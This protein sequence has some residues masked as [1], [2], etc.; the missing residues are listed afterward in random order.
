MPRWREQ[1]DEL[2]DGIEMIV[3]STADLKQLHDGVTGIEF[4]KNNAEN[5]AV[6]ISDLNLSS[7]PNEPQGYDVIAAALSAGIPA[8]RICMF[9]TTPEA[10]K[11][12][13]SKITKEPILIFDKYANNGL[14][15]NWLIEKLVR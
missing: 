2:Y 8:E 15:S 12:L 6:V 5:I 7:N 14:L 3:E 1:V 4:I 13:L 11:R 10:A 9:T